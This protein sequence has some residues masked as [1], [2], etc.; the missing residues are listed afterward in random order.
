MNLRKQKE[1]EFFTEHIET[2]KKIGLADPFFVIKTAFFQKGKSGRHVQF[3]Q[4]E[5]EKG[6]DIYIEFCDNVNDNNGT[7]VDI[8][9][10]L[11]DRPLFKYRVNR[12]FDEE[13]EKKEYTNFKGEPYN[14]YVVPANELL[15]VLKDGTEIT[16]SLYEKRKENKTVEELLPKLQQNLAPGL[17]PDF[18]EMTKKPELEFEKTFND[19]SAA[20]IL[21]RIASDFQKLALKLK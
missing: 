9:P 18:E 21:N 10:M 1:N 15:V 19:E 8:K 12:Y 14:L 6:Q 4:S 7:L 5:L 3:F 17:F 13:Y 16:Y 11:A 20:D 2:F